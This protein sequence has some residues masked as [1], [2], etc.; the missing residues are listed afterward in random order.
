MPNRFDIFISRLESKTARE[1]IPPH[2]IAAQ[3]GARRGKADQKPVRNGEAHADKT[4][5]KHRQ[6]HDA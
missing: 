3:H 5:G 6:K 1:G 4:R 2:P